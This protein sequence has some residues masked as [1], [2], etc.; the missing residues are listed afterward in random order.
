MVVH[1]RHP[2]ISKF[3]ASLSYLDLVSKIQNKP[4]KNPDNFQPFFLWRVE[5]E[6]WSL[7]KK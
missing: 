2:N 1:A 3:E 4:K 7:F 5:P 6:L